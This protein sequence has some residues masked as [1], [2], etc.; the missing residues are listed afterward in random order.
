MEKNIFQVLNLLRAG[1]DLIRRQKERHAVA[2]MCLHA[3][4]MAARSSAFL[5][6]SHYLSMGI[7]LLGPRRWREDYELAL[8]LHSAGAEMGI[9]SGNLEAME[10]HVN[11]VLANARQFHDTMHARMAKFY[12]Y[13]MQA[14][15]YYDA[16]EEGKNLLRYLGV[17]FPAKYSK[18]R[19]VWELLSVRRLVRGKSDQ[20]FMR[21][22]ALLNSEKRFCLQIL[23][24]MCQYGLFST[25]NM[26]PF[27]IL[28]MMKIT[29]LNG[30][31]EFASTAIVSY[32]M[33]CI[34][35]Y[36]DVDM[37]YRFGRLGLAIF[38]RDG[39]LEFLPRVHGTF[40]GH[41]LVSKRPIAEMLQPVAR[42]YR[43]GVHTGDLQGA[44]LCA[45]IFCIQLLEAGVRL[46]DV[47]PELDSI[48]E[49]LEATNQKSM[50][51]SFLPLSRIVRDLMGSPTNIAGWGE[52][53]RVAEESGVPLDTISVMYCQLALAWVHDDFE[54]V[55]TMMNCIRHFSSV[56][57]GAS[58]VGLLGLI[59]A[60]AM[61]LAQKGIRRTKNVRLAKKMIKQ[62]LVY[63]TLEPSNAQPRLHL[64]Q[65]ELAAHQGRNGRAHQKYLTAIAL[66]AAT[67]CRHVCAKANECF[68]RH[69]YR[70][71]GEDAAR[72]QDSFRY[73]A[74]ACRIYKDWGGILKYRSLSLEMEELFPGSASSQLFPS[75]KRPSLR[76]ALPKSQ[77]L[78]RS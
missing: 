59:G 52:L 55:D 63:A 53:R 48:Q 54:H 50:S 43:I 21:M 76:L 11:S 12:S 78:S 56:P 47:E 40:F 17:R 24:L 36:G 44:F 57:Q 5:I 70:T 29:V 66:S 62:L 64:V 60:Y 9:C 69:L 32:G 3:G 18:V 8:A 68:A 61:G 67:N 38:D 77:A 33:L 7:A 15:R 23:T 27:V 34:A 39:P 49:Q 13:G 42:A 58:R 65:G 71:S 19:L 6:A 37:G 51:I 30:N 75:S 26:L 1:Q 35:A 10:S 22:P 72:I 20:F 46:S 74:E 16:F 4:T 31:S 73:F 2:S 28:R 25:P 45:N 41:V 14:G